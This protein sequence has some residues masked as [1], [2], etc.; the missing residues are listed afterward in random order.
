MKGELVLVTVYIDNLMT[1]CRDKNQVLAVKN[2]L[3]KMFSI[4]Y[5]GKIIHYLGIDANHVGETGN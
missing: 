3:V 5:K 1:A 4:A 2:V